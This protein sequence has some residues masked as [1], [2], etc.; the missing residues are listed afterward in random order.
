[1]GVAGSQDASTAWEGV[2]KNGL[3]L[4]QVSGR[5]SFA[6]RQ[7]VGTRHDRLS[8]LS[9]AGAWRLI[10]QES[11]EAAAARVR[12]AVPT[13]PVGGGYW[14]TVHGMQPASVAASGHYG[15]VLT[16]SQT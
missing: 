15:D 6:E 3:G 9:R 4:E 2:D 1:M 8:T 14:L 10:V 7:R 12:V 16:R 5:C 13:S 11:I